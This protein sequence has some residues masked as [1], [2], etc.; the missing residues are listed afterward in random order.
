MK[1]EIPEQVIGRS[2]LTSDG[3]KGGSEQYPPP[4][5]ASSRAGCAVPNPACL[6]PARQ[7]TSLTNLD[8]V[9]LCSP[10]MLWLSLPASTLSLLPALS[11]L[12]FTP[13]TLWLCSSLDTKYQLDLTLWEQRFT[14]FFSLFLCCFSWISNEV[15]GYR[16]FDHWNG[17]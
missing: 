15:E 2:E 5:L 12:F 3:R 7:L 17:W 11:C 1:Q 9:C 13:Y 6:H 4:G 14:I 16:H 8:P 10:W